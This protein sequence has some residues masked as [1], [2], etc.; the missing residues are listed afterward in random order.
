M[1]FRDFCSCCSYL[2]LAARA[3]LFGV[4]WF[5]PWWLLL[6]YCKP[7]AVAGSLGGGSRDW[8]MALT[9]SAR[10]VTGFLVS[11]ICVAGIGDGPPLPESL[12][13][14]YGTMPRGLGE[15]LSL[16][17]SVPTCT[18]FKLG[19]EVGGRAFGNLRARVSP[20]GPTWLFCCAVVCP[21]VLIAVCLRRICPG[22]SVLAAV[23]VSRAGTGVDCSHQLERRRT[24]V[25]T[26]SLSG[27]TGVRSCV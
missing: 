5:A 18:M 24:R 4:F 16:L 12:I 8:P 25:A 21:I 1:W 20:V 23:R 26:L 15:V 17:R 13:R 7:G 10:L 14:S 22:H 6:F 27:S 3:R 19:V 2:Y 11:C 9:L